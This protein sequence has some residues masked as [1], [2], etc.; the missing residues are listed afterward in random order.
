MTDL[1]EK[2]LK[3]L[4]ENH[5]YQEKMEHDACGVGLVVSTEGKKSRRV[6]DSGIEALKAVSPKPEN[7]INMNFK[8]QKTLASNLLN[9]LKNARFAFTNSIHS[10][11]CY[12]TKVSRSTWGVGQN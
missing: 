8:K 2:N 9:N 4:K 5:V 1:R 6:V 10:S 11:A 3:L 12:F 7:V